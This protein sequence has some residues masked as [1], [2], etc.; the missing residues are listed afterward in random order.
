[1]DWK[2]LI[3]QEIAQ[4]FWKDLQLYFENDTL[5][6]WNYIWQNYLSQKSCI[7]KQNSNNMQNK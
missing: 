3:R 2:K 7:I 1:M 4:Q 5:C 6:N